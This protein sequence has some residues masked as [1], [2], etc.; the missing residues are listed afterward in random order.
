MSGD[1][2][3]DATVIQRG[4]LAEVRVAIKC[5]LPS[6]APRRGELTAQENPGKRTSEGLQHHNATQRRDPAEG[7]KKTA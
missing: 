2:L 6:E 4:K 7:A 3:V 5:M 1:L